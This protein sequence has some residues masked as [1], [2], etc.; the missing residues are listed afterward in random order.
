ME[1]CEDEHC[2]AFEAVKNTVW[3]ST[4][5]GTPQ[6]VVNMGIQARI[7]LDGGQ[8]RFHR[9]QKFIP[10]AFTLFLIPLVGLFDIRLG[11]GFDDQPTVLYRPDRTRLLTSAQGDPA[12]GFLRCASNR[13]SSS[14]FCAS[15][16][17]T[18]SGTLA[19]LSQMSSTS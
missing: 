4:D 10:E 17:G 16:S 13:R 14:F 11:F 1:D 5:Q 18:A 15:D 19:T 8:G 2:G 7:A 6:G 9:Q 3:K 12:R